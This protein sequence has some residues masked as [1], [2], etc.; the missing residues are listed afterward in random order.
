MKYVPPLYSFDNFHLS[1]YSYSVPVLPLAG[2]F[3]MCQKE[4]VNTIQPVYE[5]LEIIEEKVNL[6][7]GMES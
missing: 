1:L 2:N 7:E 3:N 4:K 6:V 5:K